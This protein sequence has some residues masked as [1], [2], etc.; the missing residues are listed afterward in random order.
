MAPVFTLMEDVVLRR[1]LGKVGW[2]GGDGIFAP[3]TLSFFGSV[4]CLLWCYII[5]IIIIISISII[6]IIIMSS[7]VI[8]IIIIIMYIYI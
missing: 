8:I 7:I 3:G 4:V 6:I 2:E 5:I 1:M